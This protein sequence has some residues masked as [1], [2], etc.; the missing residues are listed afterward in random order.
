MNQKPLLLFLIAVFPVFF[1]LSAQEVAISRNSV[2]AEGTSKGAL[3]S[4]NYDHIFRLGARF[5]DTYRIGFSLLNNTIALPLGINFLTGDGFHH[6][7]FGL[8]LVPLV[9]KYQQL[10]SAG[11]ISDKKLYIIPGAGYRYQPPGGGFFF[12]IIAAPII[13]LDPPSDHFWKMDG[14]VY[15]GGSIGAG[16]SF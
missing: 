10:F 13:Y 4:I 9:E 15:A 6:V 5:T 16:I 8:T 11:N 1:K 14:T 3:Y 2:Y 12:K 7:E